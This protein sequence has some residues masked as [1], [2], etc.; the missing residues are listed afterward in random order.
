VLFARVIHTLVQLKQHGYVP[1]IR[2]YSKHTF[3]KERGKKRRGCE[4]SH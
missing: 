3:E 1:Q 2:L 4:N